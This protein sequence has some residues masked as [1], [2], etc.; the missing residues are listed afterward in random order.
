MLPGAAILAAWCVLLSP[1]AAGQAEEPHLHA[2]GE[3]ERIVELRTQIKIHREGVISVQQAFRICVGGGTIKRGPVLNYL[4]VFDGPG[5]LTLD[6][7]M[8]I[9]KVLKEGLPEPFHIEKKE[10]FITLYVGSQEVELEEGDYHYSIFYRTEADWHQKGG[11]F[12]AVID[13]TSSLPGLPI[14]RAEVRVELPEGVS[15]S[16]FTPAITGFAGGEEPTDTGFVSETEGSV[17]TVTTTRTLGDHRG[18]F[19]NLAWPSGTF[20]SQGQWMK[21]LAQHPRIPLSAFS[22]VILLWVLIAI[23]SRAGRKPCSGVR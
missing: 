7:G 11:E 4:T 9:E 23:L 5:G 14:D 15:I 17:V 19:L 13:A 6:N 20:A 3:H 22:A 12:S 18:F 8:V 2:H 10:G 16:K 1:P 21:V